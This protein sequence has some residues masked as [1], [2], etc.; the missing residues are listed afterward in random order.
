MHLCGSPARLIRGTRERFAPGRVSPIPPVP[1]SLRPRSLRLSIPASGAIPPANSIR[2][3]WRL[4]G[5][6]LERLL[7]FLPTPSAPDPGGKDLIWTIAECLRCKGVSAVVAAPPRLSRIEARRLQLAAEQAAAAWV[8]WLRH[9]GRDSTPITPPP[10][11]GSSAP[12]PA[13]EPSNAGKSNSFTAT[14]G[15]SDKPSAWS[16]AVKQ[17]I[18][19]RLTQ[20]PIDRWRRSRA[21]SSQRRLEIGIG[22]H[23][24]MERQRDRE[25]ERRRDA[26]SPSLCLSVSPSLRLSVPSR[27]RPHRRRPTGDRGALHCGGRVRDSRWHDA[28]AGIDALVRARAA[29]RSPAA[30]AIGG[31]A[32]ELRRG[33]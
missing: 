31:Q 23:G 15:A 13:G 33:G 24:E 26:T 6:P 28:D 9:P 19:A 20:W 10:P 25:T 30:A 32:G 3:D 12:P 14:E 11:A 1:L 2:R 7:P 21:T 29:C 5:F 18:C 17:I 4:H 22:G 16:I 27:H 8:C